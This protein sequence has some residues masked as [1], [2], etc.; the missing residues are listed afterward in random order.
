M[1]NQK[2]QF[3]MLLEAAEKAKK[4]AYAP[5]SDFH[6]GAALLA[7]NG[8]IFTG[9]NIENSS[10]GATNCAER[11]ALFKAVSEGV[12]EFAAIA[13]LSDSEELIYPCGICR[14]A[15]N[16]F[17][18]DDF[19]VVCGNCRKEYEVYRFRDLLPHVGIPLFE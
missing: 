11:T 16:D 2:E 1:D 19:I 18:D 6:V 13:V 3:G 8:Q 12:R 15:L 10:Y 17:V 7:K 14:Q 9:V 5:F 4:N